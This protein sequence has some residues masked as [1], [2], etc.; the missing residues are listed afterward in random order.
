MTA[1]LWTLFAA[2]CLGIVHVSAD[3][4]SFKAQVGT[5]YTVGARDQPVE[6]T[7]M[8]GRLHRAA[9]NY[10]ENLILFA[11]VVMMLHLS[12]HSQPLS[13]WGAY[14][15]VVGRVAYLG[16]YA[17]GLP[18]VRTVC[19]QVSMVGLVMMMVALFL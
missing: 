15:W 13:N 8:A 9:R 14:A 1:E 19:W 16:A 10:T 3:S 5:A 12:E 7:A 2:V 17:S 11:A 18:W 4:F 6:R